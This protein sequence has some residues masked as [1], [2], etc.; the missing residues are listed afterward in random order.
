MD[1]LERLNIFVRVVDCMSFTRAA[2]SLEIPR[3]TVSTAIK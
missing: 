2:G 3:S 1:R